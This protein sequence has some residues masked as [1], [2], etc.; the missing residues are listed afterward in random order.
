MSRASP[1]V[2]ICSSANAGGIGTSL[3]LVLMPLLL[4]IGAASAPFELWSESA[5]HRQPAVNPAINAYYRDAD[6]DRWK[7]IFESPGREVFRERFRIVQAVGPTPGMRVADVGAGTGFFTM[8]FARAV[9]PAGR[10]YAIDISENFLSEIRRRAREEYHV[11]NV[12]TVLNDQRGI[13]LP[14]DS[15]DLVFLCDT[16]HH[17]EYPRQM[18]ASISAALRDGGQLVLVDFHRIQGVSS[19][20]V[21]SH[22]RANR[23]EV[24]EEL[25]DAGFKLAGEEDFLRENF[26]LRFRKRSD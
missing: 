13:G 17:F 16:Y 19:P 1:G 25:N 4:A 7:F 2:S 22:V 3:R 10:V 20:W 14:A 21:M 26:F 9:G 8:L 18:L 11:D 12:E 6:L 5:A 24:I 23:E 15:L